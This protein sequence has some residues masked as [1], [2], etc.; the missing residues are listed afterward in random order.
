MNYIFINIFWILISFSALAQD[1]S[2]EA[3]LKLAKIMI[4]TQKS[5][6]RLSLEVDK[7]KNGSFDA[8]H[9]IIDISKCI[10][11]TSHEIYFHCVDD[12]KD[13]PDAMAKTSKKSKFFFWKKN[14]PLLKLFPLF[15]QVIPKLQVGTLIHEISHLCGTEDLA[16]FD[17]LILE[18]SFKD[19]QFDPYF[20]NFH[21]TE[22]F[23]YF[24]N[25]KAEKYYINADNYRIWSTYSFCIPGEDCREK[26]LS[27]KG[28]SEIMV[29]NVLDIKKNY[30]IGIETL[31]RSR[32]D[33]RTFL[34][35]RPRYGNKLSEQEI[36][37]ILKPLE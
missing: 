7:Y 36:E 14:P 5:A 15:W 12:E 1:C 26:Y 37:D 19:N 22:M 11:K 4:L 6:S 25:S 9:K 30:P 24:L 33:I 32:E 8:I 2:S 18:E 13:H 21:E 3:Q 28:R 35:Q 27:S 16:Y 31:V 23:D 17:G 20:I 34:N 10:E 29:K